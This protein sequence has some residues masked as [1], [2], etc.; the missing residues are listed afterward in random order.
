MPA[1]GP[2]ELLEA[3]G[4]GGMAR[5]WRARAPEGHEVA[6]KVLHAGGQAG[7]ADVA[8]FER[9]VRALARVE[10]PSLIALLDHGVDEAMGPWLAMPLLRGMTLR[11]CFAG[12]RLAP[13][14]ALVVLAPVVDALAALHDEGLVHRDV[15]PENVVLDPLGAVTLVDLGL[16]LGEEDTRHTREGEVTGSL[17]YMS[18]ERIEG[19][20]VSASADVWALGVMFYELVAG[21]RPFARSRPGEEV[22]AILAG[23]FPPLDEVD[24]RVAPELASLVSS[25]LAA[26]PSR[27]LDHAGALAERWRP[28]RSWPDHGIKR[29]VV[30][31]LTDPEAFARQVAGAVASDARARA[32]DALRESDRFGAIRHLERALAYRPGDAAVAELV[33]R[34]ASGDALPEGAISP[35]APV[36]TAAH[37][38]RDPRRRWLLPLAAVFGV[39]VPATI[40]LVWLDE[41]A[42]RMRAVDA[43][44]LAASL[45]AG[46]ADAGGADVGVADAG[47]PL[48]F[49]RIPL[50][51]LGNDDPV[52][53]DDV[54][55]ADGEPLVERSALSADP[56]D[57]LRVA[58]RGL[59]D[60]PTDVAL[61][62]DEAMAMLSLGRR[63]EGLARLDA[64]E[65]EH[66][67]DAKVMTAVG[68]VAMRR[69]DY[70]RADAAFDAALALEP[71]HVPALRHRGMLRRRLG[72]TRDA[73]EDLVRV[74]ELEPDNVYALA[75][76]TD[77]Y[78]RAQ[79]VADAL[80]LLE[81]L[82]RN[83]PTN[84]EAWIGLSISRDASGD[85]EGAIAAIERALA[86]LP[87]REKAHHM[88]CTLLA[89]NQRP[90]ARAAC[91]AAI[92]RL[93]NEPDLLA[94]RALDRARLGDVQGALADADR[95][96]ELAPNVARHYANRA[97]LRGRSGDE[98]AAYADLR[99]ACAL[100][101]ARSCD[102]LRM[103]GLPP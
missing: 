4:E 3:I 70:A 8:R 9:E 65:A 82:T 85:V 103:S 30:S 95:A 19:R 77:A 56:E 97:I 47:E 48:V 79:R 91:D 90:G 41:D 18:P 1:V 20:E 50:H 29:G 10:H 100:G 83:Y 39:A 63:A 44:A 43:S 2:Y 17:P 24:P 25:C 27:R 86:I 75:E 22:A 7:P 96:V 52:T 14:A 49:R 38:V 98:P 80:P 68:F 89:R 57:A 45:D 81:R 31:V 73:Y 34:I 6:V 61:R 67:D 26:D 15:K 32:E 33:D 88:R 72:R 74:L 46:V 93:P 92:E 66:S 35:A 54:P 23:A 64:L 21:A 62:V 37:P 94:A 71:D 87:D 28:W 11:D 84:V 42:P 16:A 51:L 76:I 59:E 78:Q 36:S 55:A 40:G 101:D 13:E 12:K 58:I 5:V 60:D 69:A 53:L 99:R 102:R